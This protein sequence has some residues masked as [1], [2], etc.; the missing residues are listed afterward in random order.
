MRRKSRKHGGFPSSYYN[1]KFEEP[2]ASAGVASAELDTPF[3]SG[4]SVRGGK[5]T[6]RTKRRNRRNRRNTCKGGFVPSVMGGFVTA[7][8][9]YIFPISMFSGY[10]LM[11]RSK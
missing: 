9:K 11:N 4:I 10:K 8:S 2:A 3:G 6:K 7:V 5:R 1:P